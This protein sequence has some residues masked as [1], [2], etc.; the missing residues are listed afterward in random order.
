MRPLKR[1]RGRDRKWAMRPKVSACTS[2]DFPWEVVMGFV[3]GRA[4]SVI[5][6]QMVSK[7]VRQTLLSDHLFWQRLFARDFHV[8]AYLYQRVRDPRFPELRLWKAD[9]TSLARYIG[10]LHIYA[11]AKEEQLPP[12]EALTSYIC[13]WFA[14]QY[15]PRCGVCGCRHRHEP[16]WSLG[17][18]VC[19]L[20]MAGNSLS[21]YEMSRDYALEY[22]AVASKARHRIWYYSVA[23]GLGEDRVPFTGVRPLPDPRPELHFSGAP[24]LRSTMTF[25]P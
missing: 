11:S 1:Q 8:K 22:T 13:K 5:L 18:R 3:R 6:M 15:G 2:V 25:L 17:M 21:A 4:R 20:C 24:T 14:L 16:Y 23:A 10:P 7:G 19:R 9:L 12:K